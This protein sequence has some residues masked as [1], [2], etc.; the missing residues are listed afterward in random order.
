MALGE[1]DSKPE[2]NGTG[3]CKGVSGRT[4]YGE[5]YAGRVGRKVI[6]Q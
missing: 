2:E 6:Y 3:S 1:C 4:L 5:N